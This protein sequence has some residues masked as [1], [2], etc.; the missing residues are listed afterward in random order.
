MGI[1]LEASKA[2]GLEVNPEKTKYMIMSRDQ[3]IVRNGNIKIGDL[4]FEEVEKFKYLGAT[5]TNMNDT[6]EEIKRRINLGNACYYSLEKLLSSSLLS[7]NLKVRIYKIVI[8]PVV[9]YGCETWT[10]ILREEQRLR[11][12]ENKVLRKIFWDKWDEVTGE[13]K[14]L[15][16][17]ELHALY[18]SP[19]IIRNIK[20]RRLKWAGHVARMR[21]CRNACR[22]LVGRPE[23]KRPLGRP[24]RRWADNIKMDL[25][26][27]G[28]DDREWINL[29]QDRDRRRAYVRAEMNLRDTPGFV[30]GKYPNLV[31]VTS[32]T[33]VSD[34]C[35]SFAVPAEFIN[36]TL[37]VESHD[38][39]T[40]GAMSSSVHLLGR[41]STSIGS[42]LSLPWSAYIHMS[43]QTATPPLLFGREAFIFKVEVHVWTLSVYKWLEVNSE[44]TKYMIMSRDQN[45]VRNGTI[46]VGD[47]SFEEVEKFKYLRAT[48]TNINDTREEIKRRINMGNAC[49]Y[50]VEKL[51]S[52]SL[53]SKNLKV[54]IYKT[55][56]L[57]V[58]LYGCETWTLTLRE[59]QRLRVFENK[60]LRKIF[61]AKRDEV[62]GEWR[63]LHNTELHALKELRQPSYYRGASSSRWGKS[64]CD[65]GKRT[66]PVRKYDSILK[67]LSLLENAN[68]FLERTVLSNSVLLTICGL[69]S[70]WSWNFP[71]RRGGSE[72][73]S[74]TQIE[75]FI[76]KVEVHA[77]KLSVYKSSINEWTTTSAGYLSTRHNLLEHSLYC[78]KYKPRITSYRDLKHI[79]HDELINDALSLP[80]TEVW[81]LPDIDDKI[82]KFNDLVIQL[83]DKHAPLKTRRV[84]RHPAPWMCDAIKLLMTDR[85]TAYRKYRRSK[86]ELDFNTYKVL[87]NKC[88][89]AVRNAKLRHAHSLILPSVSAKELWRNLNNLGLTKAKPRVDNINLSLNSLNEHF[90][91]A[92]PEPLHKQETLEFL[93]SYPQPVWINSS[94]NTLTRLT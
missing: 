88:N 64:G 92:P 86:D 24:R 89:Q 69:G 50:S 58:V 22:L 16:N 42:Y 87:R 51:L 44:K 57:P 80:W 70:V 43:K 5:V 15:H 10:L 1:L 93:R 41:D 49:Y 78:P 72:V 59:E 68:I 25:R 29:A 79:E 90:V 75:A 40:L 85:D 55:V 34:R 39:N 23:G 7:K 20:S 9:L 94:L 52:S 62:T 73:H 32:H 47:L 28:F 91:T 81:N 66:V 33:R 76:F 46:K 3:N 18:S 26:E 74:K 61:G 77:W 37:E 53:L 82:E 71:S 60:V 4:S 63:K 21:E 45:I 13:W 36:F 54:R 2:I 56:I 30:S 6:R 27:M 83:Y 84:G 17:A 35:E 8:L 31:I 11:V 19:D 48:V 65:I 38:R 12:L 67:A 14:K